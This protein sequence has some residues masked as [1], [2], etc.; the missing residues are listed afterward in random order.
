[1]Q[2]DEQ[3][4][5]STDDIQEYFRSKR[6]LPD[7]NKLDPL[8]FWIH[9]ENIY[10]TLAPFAQDILVIPASSTPIERVFSKAG[11]SSS[12]RRNRLAGRNLELEVLLKTNKAYIN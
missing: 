5:N 6:Q 8:D 9:N 1:M 7:K 11:Y 3:E 12:G 10:P 4:Q 2:Q